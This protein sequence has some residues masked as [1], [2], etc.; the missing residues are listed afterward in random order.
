MSQGPTP[1]SDLGAA[2]FWGVG[3]LSRMNLGGLM[4]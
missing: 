3:K 4:D 2:T 1:R